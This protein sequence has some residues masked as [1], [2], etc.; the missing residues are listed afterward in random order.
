MRNQSWGSLGDTGALIFT[1]SG[2]IFVG[3]SFL[4]AFNMGPEWLFR[5]DWFK[6]THMLIFSFWNGYCGAQCAVK[7]PSKAPD[8]LKETVGSFLGTFIPIGLMIGSLISI[9]FQQLV[10]VNYKS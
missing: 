10:P 9:G 1:Y 7:A 8:Y 6:I 4:I 2:T 5:S 3:T